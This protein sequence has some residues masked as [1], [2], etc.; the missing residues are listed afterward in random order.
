MNLFVLSLC[1]TLSA[2]SVTGHAAPPAPQAVGA[3]TAETTTARAR[4]KVKGIA[5]GACAARI[6]DALQRHEGVLR[7]DIDVEQKIVAVEFDR[8]KT[9][10]DRIRAEI[11]R[12]GFEAKPID[13]AR[14]G[15][16]RRIDT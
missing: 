7:V 1:F 2:C 15:G 4:Y 9:T 10:P 12:L 6:R 14:T 13:E 11:E 8:A 3:Q 5:C 16:S